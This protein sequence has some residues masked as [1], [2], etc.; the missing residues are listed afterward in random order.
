MKTVMGL[1]KIIWEQ[2]RE[3][4]TEMFAEKLH[5][6]CWSVCVCGVV[7]GFKFIFWF[8][9]KFTQPRM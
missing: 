3:I 4:K 6:L 7:L 2:L 5:S 9:V 8:A 1:N